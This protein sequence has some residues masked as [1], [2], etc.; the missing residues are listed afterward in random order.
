VALPFIDVKPAE[1][2]PVVE[3]VARTAPAVADEQAKPISALQ[4]V[5]APFLGL[6]FVMFLPIIGIGAMVWAIS[7]RVGGLFERAA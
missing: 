5:A 7:K 2:E 3:A 1:A 4:F 6:A